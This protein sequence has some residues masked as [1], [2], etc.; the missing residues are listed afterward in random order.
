MPFMERQIEFGHWLMVATND[1]TDYIP[2]DLVSLN[3]E[4]GEGAISLSSLYDK[5]TS[6]LPEGHTSTEYEIAE[7]AAENE[8]ATVVAYVR[9][10]ASGRKIQSVELIEGWGARLSAPGYMDCTEW[11]VFDSEE[12]AITYLDEMY[13]EGDE[14]EED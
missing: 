6:G 4:Q 3:I 13:P 8:W 5:H 11:S 7:T 2:A 9:D 14:G 12:E 10:Y 1:G